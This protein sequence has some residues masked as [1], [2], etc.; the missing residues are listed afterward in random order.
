MNASPAT[1]M[2]FASL[3]P[4]DRARRSALIF[5]VQ[6]PKQSLT[7]PAVWSDLSI[8]SISAPDTS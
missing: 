3:N 5:A 4:G 6:A 7:R 8:E 1:A 2:T